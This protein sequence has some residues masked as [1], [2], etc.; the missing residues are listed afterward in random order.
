MSEHW[1]RTWKEFIVA[2]LEVI[3]LKPGACYHSEIVKGES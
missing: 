2:Y 1:G 3:Y